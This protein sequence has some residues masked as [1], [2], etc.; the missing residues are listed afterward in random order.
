MPTR[1]RG[2]T[3]ILSEKVDDANAS[4]TEFTFRPTAGNH[5]AK[6]PALAIS[7]HQNDCVINISWFRR[8]PDCR[9]RLDSSHTIC[10]AMDLKLLLS[11]IGCPDRSPPRKRVAKEDFG[12]TFITSKKFFRRL[13]L[14]QI[15][16]IDWIRPTNSLRCFPFSIADK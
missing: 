13:G 8:P 4:L 15:F 12:G 14:Q 6:A 3:V 1:L 7:L 16:A 2:S 5:I 9:D 10:R 11:Y